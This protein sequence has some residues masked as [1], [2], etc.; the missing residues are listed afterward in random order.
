MN[1]NGKKSML[2]IFRDS[3][4]EALT[5]MA[6]NV[7]VYRAIIAVSEGGLHSKS[8]KHCTLNEASKFEA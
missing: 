7:A 4:S 6:E 1:G 5:A 2:Y 8:G 3:A